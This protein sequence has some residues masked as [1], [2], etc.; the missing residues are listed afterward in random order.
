MEQTRQ[1]PKLLRVD[2]VA[3]VLNCKVQ[4]VY[5][6]IARRDLTSI[7]VGSKGAHRIPF[8]CLAQLLEKGKVPART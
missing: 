5:S 1:L 6:M 2:E 7:R 4:T 3:E 8:D